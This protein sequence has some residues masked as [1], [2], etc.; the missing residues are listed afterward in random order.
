MVPLLATV[1]CSIVASPFVN[2]NAPT[3]SSSLSFTKLKRDDMAMA[4]NS[5]SES[6]VHLTYHAH[7]E[8]E[9]KEEEPMEET[10]AIFTY[11]QILMC[12]PCHP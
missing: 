12:E 2:S 4:V 6:N 3:M 8:G 1:G 7:L 10:S 5:T 11:H 9:T